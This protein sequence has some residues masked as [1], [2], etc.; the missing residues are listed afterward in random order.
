MGLE[1]HFRKYSPLHLGNE[2]VNVV[3]GCG[4]QT[5]ARMRAEKQEANA[6]GYR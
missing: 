5:K 6:F 2:G 3:I 4:M 1:D